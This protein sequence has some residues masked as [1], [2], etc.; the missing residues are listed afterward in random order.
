MLWPYGTYENGYAQVPNYISDLNAMNQA[1]KILP[2]TKCATYRDHLEGNPM[3][4][5]DMIGAC[6][7]WQLV[8]A[9]AAQRAEA[10]LKTLSL[11]KP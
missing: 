6:I 7:D 2:S 8:H 10:F 4:Q 11:W 9:G 3:V 5:D 1:E